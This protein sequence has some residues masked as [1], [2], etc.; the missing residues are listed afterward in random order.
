MISGCSSDKKSRAPSWHQQLATALCGK[1]AP[2]AA[3]IRTHL[4][5][6][7]RPLR[8]AQPPPVDDIDIRLRTSIEVAPVWREIAPSHRVLDDSRE[9]GAAGGTLRGL[10]AQSRRQKCDALLARSRE[11]PLTEEEKQQLR[12]LIQQT[13]AERA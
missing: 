11:G 13:A 12:E 1:S 6:F 10:A 7:A 8:Q 4:E 3:W 2:A 5:P 9:T